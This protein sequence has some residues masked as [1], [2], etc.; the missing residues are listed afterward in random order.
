MG[1]SQW[2]VSGSQMIPHSPRI[3]PEPFSDS[4]QG[5]ARFVAPDHLNHLG[6]NKGAV[7]DANASCAKQ[8][9]HASP[10]DAKLLGNLPECR[11]LAVLGFGA[12]EVLFP[13][14]RHLADR[15]PMRLHWPEHPSADLHV[16]S[17]RPFQ[18]RGKFR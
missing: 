11:S 9:R 14:P 13:E 8:H 18:R 4:R 5:F 16:R 3:E 17:D 1:V 10:V 12:Q 2:C 15:S 7:T 6:L